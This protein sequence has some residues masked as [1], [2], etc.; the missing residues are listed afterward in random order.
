MLKGFAELWKENYKAG[1]RL[2]R[3]GSQSRGKWTNNKLNKVNNCVSKIVLFEV[4]D[5]L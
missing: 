2:A 1:I 4:L 5:F 3:S